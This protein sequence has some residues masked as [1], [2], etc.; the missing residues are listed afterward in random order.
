MELLEN[1][2]PGTGMEAVLIDAYQARWGSVPE[3]ARQTISNI[4]R[5]QGQIDALMRDAEKGTPYET[6]RNGRQS[7]KRPRKGLELAAK[8]MREVARLTD[9]LKLSPHNPR[10]VDRSLDDD[11]PETNDDEVDAFDAL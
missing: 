9:S 3:P 4:A 7:F 5:L 10:G 6:V 1:K 8:L 11:D 2:P